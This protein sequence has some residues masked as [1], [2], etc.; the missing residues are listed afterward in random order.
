MAKLKVKFHPLFWIFL[1]ILILSNNF[2][3]VFSYLLCVI[4]HE[5]GHFL[6][7]NFLGYKLNQITFLPFGVSLSGKENVFYKPFHEVLIAI[8]GPLINLVLMIICFALFWCFPVIYSFLDN[9]YFANLITFIFNLLPVYPLDG[10]RVLFATLKKNKPIKNAYKIVK[11][12]GV[13][14][15]IMLFV[16]FLISSFFK[17]NFT[18]GLTA[19]FLLAGVFFEDKSSY[20]VTNFSFLNKQNKLTTG[21]ETNI[22][23]VN[24]N[25]NLYNVLKKLNK[26]KYN[27]INVIADNGKLLKT[28]TEEEMNDI[29]LNNS[30]DKKIGE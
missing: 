27:I 15:S 6:M 30:L 12:V 28:Y 11:I 22:L 18:I 3:S 24:K 2:L 1:I 9:F 8:A 21:L 26:F 16:M 7:S 19:I 23:S 29:F 10:G 5:F 17:I 4:L 14:I 20:Y 25:A 13:I